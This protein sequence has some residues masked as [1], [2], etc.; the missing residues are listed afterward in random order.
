MEE[1]T[2]FNITAVI[3]AFS[4]IK[5]VNNS[6]LALATQWIP[7]DT[8]ELE[9]IIVNDNANKHGEYDY[10]LSDEF[11]HVLKPNIT[12]KIIENLNNSGQ[13]E[14]RNYG[15]KAAKNNWILLCDED[16]SYACNAVYRFWE[17]LKKRA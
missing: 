3:P 16:D 14:S 11:K 4:D 7:D 9:I 8:F 15:I 6:V 13:G 12:I 2:Q 17:I 5:I 10:Y 1:K